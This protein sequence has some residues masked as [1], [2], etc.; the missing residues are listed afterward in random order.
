MTEI[1]LN[2]FLAQVLEVIKNF[3]GLPTILKISAITALFISALKVSF[4]N[5]VL[6]SKMGKFKVW[7]AP[8]LGLL[9]GILNLGNQGPITFASVFAYV[10]AG[11]GAIIL[12][13]LLDSVKAIPK[14]GSFFTTVVEMLQKALKG[15][16]IK[17]P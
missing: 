9:A 8:L 5:Q 6:W 1:S 7:F 10:S 11:A 16:D 14:L 12:H 4:L 2:D 3:G 15:P 17:K 13:E